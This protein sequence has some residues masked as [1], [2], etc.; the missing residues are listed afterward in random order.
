MGNYEVWIGG[1]NPDFLNVNGKKL[2]IEMFGGYNYYHWEEEVEERI[3]HYR[4]Y[5]FG[6]LVLWEDEVREDLVVRKVKEFVEC[7]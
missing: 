2:V 4:N 3:A 6:C 7:N 5:G 1:K